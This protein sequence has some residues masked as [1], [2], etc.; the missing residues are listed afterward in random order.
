MPTIADKIAEFKTKRAK[1][2]DR[3]QEFVDVSEQEDRTFTDEE[4]S[5][6]EECQG[7]VAALDKQI[8][9]YE[10]LDK[11][12]AKEAQERAARATAATDGGAYEVKD[13]TRI[14]VVRNLP[15]G[16]AFTR[17]ALAFMCTKGVMADAEVYAKRWAD[18]PEVLHAVQF[19]RTLGGPQLMVQRAA[20]G[21]GT[22][23]DPT[24]AAPL[25]EYQNMSGE[26]IELLRPASI[27]GQM[28]AAGV[29]FRRVPFGVRI[30]K[31]IAAS[32]AQWVGEGQSKPVS[33]PGFGS[34]TFPFSKIAVIV[35]M[36]EELARF[37][38][39]DAE[40]LARNDMVASIADF[41]NSQLMDITVAPVPNL[42]PGSIT[43]LGTKTPSTGSTLAQITAD[44]NGMLNRMT[45][46]NL[47]TSSL[48][49]VMN[50]R[51]KNYLATLR[52]SQDVYAFP[53]IT[54]N[55]SLLGYPIVA[56]NAVP[57]DGT[58]ETTITLLDGA[59]VL[60]ADDG[61]VALDTSTEASVQMDSAP[62]TPAVNLVSL[63]QQN[64][65]GIRAERFLHWDVANAAGVQVLTDVT[66]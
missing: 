58:S 54:A 4:D 13:P 36:T 14:K 62:P 3:M 35:V 46:A 20:V 57:I 66:Y 50:P 40:V 22:T 25:I 33:R 7:E 44:L 6:F 52:T 60:Y 26:F 65:L 17:Y 64:L 24:F 48:A 16:I 5:Q 29:N 55:G 45:S 28:Q 63:W 34:I 11:A 27:V 18:T 53:T 41:A 37:S 39:P 61:Q 42:S 23:T 12:Q 47:S 43:Y 15:P 51:T 49:W 19:A 21:V 10:R 8:E 56:S 38:N 1:V 30:P 32:V 2:V 9:R 31:Q 59:Q